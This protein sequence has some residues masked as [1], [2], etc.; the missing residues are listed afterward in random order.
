[1]TDKTV[2]AASKYLG[3]KVDGSDN[4]N[5]SL[6]VPIPRINNRTQY[7]I[8]SEN[9]PFY[10]YDVW[11]AYEFSC[12]CD[13]GLPITR[14]LKLS[15][16]CSSEYIVESKSLKLYLNSFNMTKFGL[17]E[18]ECLAACKKIIE[19]DLGSALKT[20]IDVSFLDNSIKRE[21]VF[22]NFI[23]I[24]NYIAGKNI[25]ISQYKESPELLEC[26]NSERKSYCLKFDALRSNCRVTHQ[27]DF[28]DLFISY[29]SD[30]HITEDSLV[31]YLCSFRSEYHFHEECCEMIYKRLYDLLD[32]ED[33]LF[34]GALYTRRGGIDICPVRLSANCTIND[35][36][37][38]KDTN[39]YARNGIKQ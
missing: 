29:E 7:N 38:L 31:K 20:E 30:K 6:I 25:H 19:R 3:K 24:K 17:N 35:V 2:E 18:E 12:L 27:P 14:V 11:H 8:D 39:R 23:D 16:N 28:G 9:L 21:P 36:E 13:N 4:Y 33:K 34:V 26:E 32:K 1:M 37:I 10:G 5:P 15:Y 22:E